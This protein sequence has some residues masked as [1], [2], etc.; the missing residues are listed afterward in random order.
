MTNNKKQRTTLFFNSDIVKHAKA[1]AI[2]DGISL[3]ALVEA[4]LAQ[5]LPQETII[6]N[7]Q[8]NKD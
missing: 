3:T 6:K 7:V 4:A 5:Y 8:I 1:Q 2:L